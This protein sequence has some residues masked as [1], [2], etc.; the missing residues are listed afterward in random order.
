MKYNQNMFYCKSASVFMEGL[1]K[2]GS[3]IRRIDAVNAKSTTPTR[4]GSSSGSEKASKSSTVSV[5]RVGKDDKSSSSSQSRSDGASASVTRGDET[6]SNSSSFSVGDGDSSASPDAAVSVFSF[7]TTSQ[8]SVDDAL[9]NKAPVEE[10]SSRSRSIN[11]GR[12]DGKGMG[13]LKTDRFTTLVM[14][15]DSNEMDHKRSKI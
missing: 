15:G 5:P 1:R 2:K 3:S 12:S 14:R 11:S 6:K 9:H 7:S 10:S 13:G 8:M 4:K